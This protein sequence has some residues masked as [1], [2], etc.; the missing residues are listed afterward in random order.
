MERCN[1][2]SIPE[3][4]NQYSWFSVPGFRSIYVRIAQ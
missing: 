4:M 2:L 3:N 1:I